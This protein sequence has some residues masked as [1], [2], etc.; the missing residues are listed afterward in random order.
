MNALLEI[1]SG[2]QS[3]RKITMR[4]G[5]V[6]RVGRTE[7]AEVVVTDD[8]QMSG[9]HFAIECTEKGCR[10]LDLNS[11]NGTFVNGNRI[12]QADLKNAD[13]IVAGQTHFSVRFEKDEV[14]APPR[15]SQTAPFAPLPKPIA[16]LP[17]PRVAV[18]ALAAPAKSEPPPVPATPQE[19]LLAILRG[20]LQPVYA[21]LDAA[22]D[23][24]V[25]KVLYESKEERQSLLEGV[26]GARLVHFAPHLVR[27]PQKSPLL[28]TLVR[29]AWGKHWG[30][31]I[32]CAK[33]LPELRAHLRQFLVATV[34]GNKQLHFRYYDPRI[35]RI[36]LPTCF[37]EEINQFFGP[38]KYF[39]MEDENPEV[40]LRFSNS[41]RGV[42]LKL[43]PLA[44]PMEGQG[45]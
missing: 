23:P 28:E 10:I 26:Q 3:G 38:V 16:P 7:R 32:A 36:F 1:Q 45:A 17:Q 5:Q 29:K 43:L 12:T 33:P 44:P 13:K 6:T 35:L 9:V 18:P 31:Y 21:L 11:S 34:P 19:R 20:E 4:P 24:D 15:F 27:L 8:P 30:V 14:E 37:P 2:R 40:L 22:V 39:A 41:G 25:L 42:G